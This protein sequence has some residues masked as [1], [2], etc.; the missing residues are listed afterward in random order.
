MPVP[1][2]PALP[3]QPPRDTAT[4]VAGS[5]A[6][7]QSAPMPRT[8]RQHRSDVAFPVEN[9][10]RPHRPL[11]NRTPETQTDAWRCAEV[12]VRAAHQRQ[13][14]RIARAIR[15]HQ[16]SLPGHLRI[17]DVNLNNL[18]AAVEGSPNAVRRRQRISATGAQRYAEGQNTSLIS[19]VIAQR[20]WTA[21]VIR[22]VS[23]CA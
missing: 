21:S 11:S 12:D 15:V 5:R 4:N 22:T 18:G 9:R 17:A 8:G 2:T 20:V 13:N 3:D 19:H 14:E 10:H 16:P 7:P 6:A 1:P 23:G